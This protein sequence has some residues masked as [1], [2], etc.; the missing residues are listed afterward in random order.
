MCLADRSAAFGFP[1]LQLVPEAIFG[2]LSPLIIVGTGRLRRWLKNELG[3]DESPL[4][5]DKFHVLPSQTN[6]SFLLGGSNSETGEH[7][8]ALDA[9]DTEDISDYRTLELGA[10]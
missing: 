9:F 4:S 10:R 3:C 6:F 1:S 5:V 7:V 2:A 8:A